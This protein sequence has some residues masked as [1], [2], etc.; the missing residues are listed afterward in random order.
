[1]SLTRRTGAQHLPQNLSQKSGASESRA[2]PVVA[3][4]C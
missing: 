4:H 3:I 2:V 1:M